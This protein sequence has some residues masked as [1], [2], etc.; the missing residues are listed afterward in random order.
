MPAASDQPV[1]STGAAQQHVGTDG[2]RLAPEL[3]SPHAASTIPAVVVLAPPTEVLPMKR[4]LI[5]IA[6]EYIKLPFDL[7]R[8]TI[9]RIL[10]FLRRI[11]VEMSEASAKIRCTANLPE[12]PGQTLCSLLL[13][14]R[15]K[16]T[17]LLCQVQHDSAG[18]KYPGWWRGASIY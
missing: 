13:T 15:N 16:G 12:Q 5:E 8:K 4:L 1:G 10:P 9:N 18:F 2:C 17:V 3:A 7:H 6:V 11:G 14:F